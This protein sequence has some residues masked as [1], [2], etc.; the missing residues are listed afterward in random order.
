GYTTI[1]QALLDGGADVNVKNKMGKTPLDIAEAQ[2]FSK[3]AQLLKQAGTRGQ[4]VDQPPATTATPLPTPP[5]TARATPPVTPRTPPAPPAEKVPLNFGR[6]HALVIGNNAYT[7]MS[8]LKT[9]MN[10]ASAV[11]ELLRTMYG[12]TVMLLTNTTRDD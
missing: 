6:Y 10:D 8:P 5:T 3:I 7:D 12:F 11:A 9:A 4:S 2:G 1:V